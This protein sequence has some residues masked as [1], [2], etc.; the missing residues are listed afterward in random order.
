[1]NI[2]TNSTSTALWHDI[3]H[4]AETSCAVSLE[5]EIESYLVFFTHALYQ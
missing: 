4:E 2:L 5:E 1:M 3:V